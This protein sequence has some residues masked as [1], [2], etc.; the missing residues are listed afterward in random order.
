M[1][2]AQSQSSTAKASDRASNPAGEAVEYARVENGQIILM[3]DGRMQ[4]VRQG[5]AWGE[6]LS[7]VTSP[8]P[9]TQ[10]RARQIRAALE[11]TGF[12]Q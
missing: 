6:W 7:A 8:F 5:T 2:P 9:S 4:R 10:E 11:E 3:L 12:Y 1:T